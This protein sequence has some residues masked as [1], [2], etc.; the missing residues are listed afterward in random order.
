MSLVREEVWRE[1]HEHN[2]TRLSFSQT[3]RCQQSIHQG[4]FRV[5][6]LG[7]EFSI[8]RWVPARTDGPRGSRCGASG[9]EA[10]L[11]HQLV[12]CREGYTFCLGMKRSL[13]CVVW[14]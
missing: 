2:R 4:R 9:V 6:L 7:N 13:L 8:L 12:C 1:S 5:V 10:L 11:K 3:L 14:Q